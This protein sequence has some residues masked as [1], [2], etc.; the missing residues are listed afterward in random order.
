MGLFFSFWD[1]MNRL[2]LGLFIS[3]MILGLVGCG[4]DLDQGPPVRIA[5]DW[6]QNTHHTGLYVAKY[7]G[8]FRRE[9]FGHVEILPTNVSVERIVGSNQADVG[10][11][12]QKGFLRAIDRDIPIRSIAAV[13]QNNVEGIAVAGDSNI[14]QFKD[15]EG[16]RYG[17]Y[18]GST[19][20]AVLQFM[21]RK[22][23]GDPGKMRM[24]E[25]GDFNDLEAIRQGIV[26]AVWV[27]QGW[28]GIEAA[29]KGHPLR[30]FPIKDADGRLDPYYP[31][32]V[33]HKDAVQPQGSASTKL[34]RIMRALDA[35][36]RY[37]IEHPREASEIF[38]KE[39]PLA[40]REL[41]EASQ[42]FLAHRY[43]GRASCW[44]YQELKR[45]LDLGDWMKENQLISPSLNVQNFFT[46]D[47]LPG[48]CKALHPS[49][50]GG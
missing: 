6:T 34:H 43:Q 46:N 9:G 47:F 40:N 5:L 13:V 42:Q 50:R 24:V 3:F 21:M 29:L 1:R 48:D 28:T 39:N 12:G 41:V 20:L 10:F 49:P 31:L 18:G 25:L 15:L 30:M 23:G 36:Y 27:F 11:I 45:W 32:I 14:I 38:M 17:S 16:K 22:A 19:E 26:D 44:G 2:K 7:L 33:A 8:F 37:A 35:G 4:E